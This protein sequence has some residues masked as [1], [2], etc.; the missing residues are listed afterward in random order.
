MK[1]RH[2]DEVEFKVQNLGKEI[3]LFGRND[4][5]ISIDSIKQVKFEHS[6]ASFATVNPNKN[7]ITKKFI[8]DKQIVI[9]PSFA[10]QTQLLDSDTTLIES[11]H[12]RLRRLAI[13]SVSTIVLGLALALTPFVA[14]FLGIPFIIYFRKII[15]KNRGEKKRS[16]A[17]RW[18]ARISIFLTSIGIIFWSAVMYI[19]WNIGE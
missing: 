15:I 9:K 2:F 5:K 3:E 18:T 11:E 13:L 14:I 19:L 12:H 17:A 4:V 1:C 7:I 10:P 6:P 16:S 8:Q